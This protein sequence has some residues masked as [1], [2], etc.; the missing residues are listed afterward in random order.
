MS[1]ANG[2]IEKLKSST[3]ASK[4]SFRPRGNSMT[5]H[6]KSGQAVAV[7][8]DIEILAV[9]DI[10]LCKVNGKH[11]LHLIGAIDK[12]KYR[13]ENARG[14]INGWISKSAIYGKVI[15]VGAI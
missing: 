7:S 11:Y 3:E 15:R 14:F 9:G 8:S 12:D 2:Y 13:I 1:W 10:V 4:I 6:I 5:P